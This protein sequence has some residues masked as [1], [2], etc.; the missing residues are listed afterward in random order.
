MKVLMRKIATGNEYWCTE[1][2]RTLFVPV[3]EEPSFDVTEDPE[4]MIIGVDL[5][6]GKDETVGPNL[7]EMNAEQLLSF[8]EQNNIE[9]PGNMKKEETIRNHIAESLVA[10]A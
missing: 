5:A 4:S 9:I 10:D 1:E 3:G 6:T 2:K 8:A 7:N